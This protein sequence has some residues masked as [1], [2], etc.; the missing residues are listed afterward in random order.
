MSPSGPTPDHACENRYADSLLQYQTAKDKLAAD[1]LAAKLAAQQASS[2]TSKLNQIEQQN[3]KG[4]SQ[5]QAMQSMF[6]AISS[7]YQSKF[8]ASCSHHCQGALLAASILNAILSNKSG[9]QAGNHNSM[10]NS[11]C[12]SY[13]KIASAGKACGSDASKF[14]PNKP[15]FPNQQIDPRTG[16]CL[17]SAPPSCTATRNALL[18]DKSFDIKF[19][20]PGPSGFAGVG[21][22]FKF[23]PDGSVTTKDGKTFKESDFDSEKEMVAAGLSAQDAASALALSKN[24][25]ASKLADNITADLKMPAF[26]TFGSESGGGTMTIKTPDAPTDGSG[27]GSK[28]L[29][30]SKRDLASEGLVRNFNGDVIG[31]SNDDIF[32]MMNKRY[33]LKTDQDTFIGQ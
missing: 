5:Q 20:K 18:A 10:A 12:L 24:N 1:Q 14:D 13:N 25:S 31:I 17:A 3:K 30:G 2:A 9:K 15:A 23:N 6:S 33:N 7:M 16:Q 19:L 29:S 22:D 28:D 32:K 4:Q 11:A 8:A 27:M 21:S 26:G